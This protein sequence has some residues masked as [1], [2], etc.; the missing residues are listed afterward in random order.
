MDLSGGF[1]NR[2][3]MNQPEQTVQEGRHA[4]GR[5]GPGGHANTDKALHSAVLGV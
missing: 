5:R 2:T 1:L 4:L 3:D